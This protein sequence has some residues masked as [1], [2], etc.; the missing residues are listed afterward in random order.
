LFGNPD[1][2]N[3]MGKAARG[4]VVENYAT[5]QVLE[6]YE[7]LFSDLMRARHNHS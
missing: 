7:A 5:H 4:R 2:R 1:L 3:G 6:R